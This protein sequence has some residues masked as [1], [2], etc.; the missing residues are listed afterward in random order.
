M[1]TSEIQAVKQRFGIIG[2]S[3]SLNRAIDIAVQ[4]AGT[5][6][7]VLIQGES[8]VG[9]ENFPKIIHQYSHRKHNPYIAI[10]CGAI[11]EG[12]IDSELFGHVKGAFTSATSDRKGYFEEADGGTI[13]LDEVGELP[14]STQARLLRVLEAGEFMRVGSSRV[15]KTNV[16]VVAAT[17]VDMQQAISNGKFREDLYYRLNAVPILVPPLRNRKEDTPLLFRKFASDFAE[18][19]KMPTIKLTPEAQALLCNYYWR[20]NIRQLKNVTEQIAAI[21]QN[22]DID[23]ET[24]RRYLPEHLESNLPTI[25][26][27]KAQQEERMF[28][29]EREI[30]YQV[31]F[32]MKKDMAEMKKVV[33]E[34]MS[35]ENNINHHSHFGN[36]TQIIHQTPN[37]KQSFMPQDTPVIDT[38]EYVEESLSLSDAEK[39]MILKALEKHKGNRRRAADEL[40]ISQR[41]LYRRIREY[42]LE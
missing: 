26:S 29:N 4:V 42:G 14:I 31:L 3:S 12:T 36:E 1:E 21:E 27:N 6:L 38:E 8:G 35:Q 37:I 30:L 11:P 22:R 13:F 39:D 15:Q 9:K 17:N 5:D 20:G 24:L 34:L 32:D 10:N 7:T 23:E 19:Y 18:K 41:T 40:N 28:S 2:L 33:H 16:R 25:F